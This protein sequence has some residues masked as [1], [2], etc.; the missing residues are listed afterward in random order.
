M[1]TE[2]ALD[3]EDLARRYDTQVLRE[4][5]L[6]E[7]REA[8]VVEASR[9]VQ[10]VCELRPRHF[11]FLRFALVLNFFVYWIA[12]AYSC[13][14]FYQKVAVDGLDSL[15]SVQPSLVV[16]FTLGTQS[17]LELATVIFMSQPSSIGTETPIS[18]LR[19]WDVVAWIAGLGARTSVLLDLQCIP[20]YWRGSSLL[21]LLSVSV[22]SF[23]IGI[24]VFGVQ[25]RLLLG[26]FCGADSFSY[27]KPDLFFKGRD[28]QAIV[29][30]VDAA[31]PPT[32]DN[33]DEPEPAVPT[34]RQAL[35]VAQVDRPML[36]GAVKI[37]NMA[38]LSDF[39]MLH[40]SLVRLYIPVES[41]ESQ[42]FTS[43]VTSFSRCFCEDIIQCCLKF[44]F[45]LDIEINFL[46]LFS[47][48]VSALQAILVCV[49]STAGSEVR[50]DDEEGMSLE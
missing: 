32:E 28:A 40:A 33:E 7:R 27:D 21:F 14:S 4:F 23:A 37:A 19:D 16:F 8:I 41:R 31:P 9:E 3:L 22:Y 42:E 12:G 45:F 30:A 18:G 36:R 25:L 26:L 48:I 20:L 24:F 17:T 44:F 46:V 34:G 11:R 13:Y 2:S 10:R 15:P 6:N 29:E 39:A 43:S 49:Y 38:H 35:E 50:D 5:L 47:F 1:A